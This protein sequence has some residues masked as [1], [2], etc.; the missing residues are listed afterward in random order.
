MFF[1]I[2]VT[3]H[4]T[5]II[6]GL[7]TIAE[8][9]IY[10]S[11][12]PDIQHISI[13]KT[14]PIYS[15]W[16]SFYFFH[17]LTFEFFVL[18]QFFVNIFQEILDIRGISGLLRRQWRTQILIPYRNIYLVCLYANES[19]WVCDISIYPELHPIKSSHSTR[20]DWSFLLILHTCR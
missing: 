17:K 3:C 8:P 19:L 16:H 15:L 18:L 4:D 7:W 5:S 20:R 11:I 9:W 2:D 13:S 14:Y 1:T 12:W 10:F 6:S